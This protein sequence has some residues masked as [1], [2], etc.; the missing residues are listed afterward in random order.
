MGGAALASEL[1]A[2]R[3]SASPAVR[4]REQCCLPSTV[5][6]GRGPA[7]LATGAFR[8]CLAQCHLLGLP[9]SLSFTELFCK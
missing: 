6:R 8:F 3:V 5:R 2:Q 7:T 9:A 1:M 4:R